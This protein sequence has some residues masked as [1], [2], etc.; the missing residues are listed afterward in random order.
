[1]KY[2][3]KDGY[4]Y[5]FDLV[6]DK[7]LPQLFQDKSHFKWLSSL[8]EERAAYRYAPDKWSIKQ[9]VGHI[10]DHER[11]KM[12]RAF[13]L[14]RGMEVPLWGYDQDL[15]V[16]NSRFDELAFQQLLAD[17]QNVRHASIS[18]IESL[19]PIQLSIKGWAREYEITLEQFLK[20]VIG[21]EVHHVSI[22]QEKYI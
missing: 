4:P 15:L 20:T 16:E 19:S 18:F 1:M 12:F 2:S 10:T 13:Q 7:D 6:K 14:S 8:G 5:Y 17:F 9:V 22:L 3:P 21:H 11:I